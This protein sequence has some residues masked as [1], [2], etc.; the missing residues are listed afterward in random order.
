MRSRSKSSATAI[1]IFLG[2]GVAFTTVEAL[3]A[4]VP[5]T[6]TQV[7]TPAWRPTN[8]Y[9]FSAPDENETLFAILPQHSFGPGDPYQIHFDYE[10]E[11]QDAL[12]A[13]G[14]VSKNIFTQEEFSGNPNAVNI[15]YTSV[16][17]SDA[18]GVSRDFPAGG[19][20]IPNEIFPIQENGDLFLN[21][22]LIDPEFDG[23]RNASSNFE[24]FSHLSIMITASEFYLPPGT[25]TVGSYV[26]RET[27][28]DVNGNGWNLE[29]PF[30]VVASPVQVPEPSTLAIMAGSLAALGLL[31]RRRRSS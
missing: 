31:R 18:T 27:Q 28:R 19:P 3:A 6:L 22:V 23:E 11:I 10:T 15:A 16:P 20:I 24:G 29:I 8:F 7:G 9:M 13:Q 25:N 30:T 21:G 14:W 4:P 5:V 2:I 17:N 26:Y 1:A 12:D